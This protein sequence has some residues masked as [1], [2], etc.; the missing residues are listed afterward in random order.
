MARS[1][2][3]NKRMGRAGRIVLAAFAALLL[4]ILLLAGIGVVNASV[5][6]VRKAEVILPDLPASFDGTRILYASDIDL[7]GLNTAAKAGALFDRLQSLE[8]DVLLLGG[9][10]T[11][12]SL[13]DVLN[14]GGETADIAGK[15]LSARSDF[16]HYIG[17]FHAPLGKYAI[18]AP[19]DADRDTLTRQMSE[20]G[21]LP[22][23]DD[24]VALRRGEDA[25]WLVGV[26]EE[27]AALN[28]A[29]SAFQRDDC[30]IVTVYGP[31]VLPVLL[32]SEAS[33]GGQWSD[34][35]SKLG[36]Q[37]AP[38]STRARHLPFRAGPS[39]WSRPRRTGAKP[40]HAP[41]RGRRLRG[42]EPAPGH[43]AGGMAD[44]AAAAI[45]CFT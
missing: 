45:D 44:H 24:R 4:F 7:C 16:F 18:A 39:P 32:T 6:R 29:G 14:R 10:Y 2:K 11:A 41:N 13:L 35:T 3:K 40:A 30:V 42:P 36:G 38:R 28:S 1:Q 15:K 37:D 20:A 26:C 8:P 34:L 22:L 17:Q 21:V 23:F 5:V 31:A 19:E 9:D 33:D 12:P 25:L 27:N 43:R